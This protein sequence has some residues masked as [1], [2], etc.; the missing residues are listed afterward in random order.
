VNDLNQL[1]VTRWVDVVT[2]L[3]VLG[4]TSGVVIGSP[5]WGGAS[6]P[7]PVRV[8][9][10]VGLSVAVYPFAFPAFDTTA[11]ANLSLMSLLLRWAER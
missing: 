5:F 9:L 1:L 4:R 8:V 7:K 11:Q 10:A 3:L 2:F 6:S